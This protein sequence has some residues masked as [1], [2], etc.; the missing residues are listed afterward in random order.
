MTEMPL[1]HLVAGLPE[2]TPF[3]PPEALERELGRP[4]DLRLGANESVFGPSPLA[5]EAM[6][7]AASKVW[8]YND[9]QG[10][11]LRDALAGRLGVAL[12]EVVLGAGIDG[13][14]AHFARALLNPGETAV[15]SLGGYP[16]YEFAVAGAGGRVEAVPYRDDAP[17][18][19]GLIEAVHRH[20]AKL[21]Y[22]A[23]PDNPSGAW[24]R[25]EEV[26]RLIEA[27]PGDCAMLLDEAYVEF[28]PSAPAPRRWIDD[29]RVVRLRTF[30]KAYG[31]AGARVG[32]AFGHRTTIRAID[33]IRMH[34]EVNLVGQ[35]GALAALE[36]MAHV[37]HVLR[38]TQ[39]ERSEYQRLASALG[40]RALPSAT[41]FVALD[42]GSHKNAV[43]LVADLKAKGVFI[44]M[45]WA[46]PL[47]RCIRVTLGRPEH[48]HRFAEAV[49]EVMHFASPR[50]GLDGMA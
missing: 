19:D 33:R 5:L 27:L 47:N 44:R 10:H 28:A 31:M 37:E 30:S 14:L 41:N 3:I 45:P 23:N 13:L 22:L 4:F 17:D 48:R 43:R 24:T 26:E 18:I 35:H 20:K 32:Y 34:F 39:E 16:T 9:A 11:D 36:D 38:V 8:C 15:G 6:R 7:E 50:D 40:F 1:S 29:P 49:T 46:P 12:D 21:V 42:T 25:P 2:K